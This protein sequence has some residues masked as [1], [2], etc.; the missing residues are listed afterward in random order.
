VQAGDLGYGLVAD[1][2][3]VHAAR[4]ERQRLAQPVAVPLPTGQYRPVAAGGDARAVDRVAHF[5]EA[6]Q[7]GRRPSDEGP[8][9]D[10]VGPGND[11]GVEQLQ[12]AR[13]EQRV[14]TRDARQVVAPLGRRAARAVV[15]ALV[16]GHTFRRERG[17]RRGPLGRLVEHPGDVVVHVAATG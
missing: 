14:P 11:V 9:L 5:G 2:G 12:R 4:G 7:P 1:H 13:L 15:D 10:V 16:A 3:L 8:A 17:R 6:G